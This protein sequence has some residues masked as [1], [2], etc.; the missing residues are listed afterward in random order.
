MA[1]TIS[2]F[3]SPMTIFRDIGTDVVDVLDGS[4][5]PLR[6][7]MNGLFELDSKAILLYN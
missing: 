6:F 1:L 7:G 4:V 2:R 3:I 5:I